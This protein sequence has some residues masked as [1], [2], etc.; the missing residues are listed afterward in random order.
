MNKTME[1]KIEIRRLKICQKLHVRNFSYSDDL[2]L[3]FVMLLYYVS[4]CQLLQQ[5]VGKSTICKKTK[6][7]PFLV[8]VE[9]H[10]LEHK[11]NSI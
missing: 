10:Q 4:V 2:I 9:T 11:Y 7:K 5:I 8:K 3:C 6:Q 1:K